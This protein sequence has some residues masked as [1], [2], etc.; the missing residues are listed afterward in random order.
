MSQM[1]TAIS[2]M[3]H[4]NVNLRI[5]KE[6][7]PLFQVVISNHQIARREASVRSSNVDQISNTSHTQIAT[8]MIT[9]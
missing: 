6:L 5:S 4:F 1:S 8:M 7:S 2:S 3:V 9:L